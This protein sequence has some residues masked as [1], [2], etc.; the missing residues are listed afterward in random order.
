[1]KCPTCGDALRRKRYHDVIIDACEACKGLW[2]DERELGDFLQRYVEEHADV[3]NASM[4]RDSSP[5]RDAL[6]PEMQCPSCGV[7]MRETNYAYDSNVFVERCAQCGGIWTDKRGI[8]LLATYVRGNPK[9]DKLG[10]ALVKD[11]QKRQD[12]Q[13]LV[14]GIQ[15]LT[16]SPGLWVFVPKIVVPVGDN[17]GRR[18]F[19]FVTLGIILANVLLFAVMPHD[20]ETMLAFFTNY[21]LVPARF[22]SGEAVYGLVT[23]VFLHAGLWHLLGNA[24]FLWIF[25]DN[26]EDELGHGWFLGFYVGC[27]VMA[28]VAYL[29]LNPDSSIPM[30]GASGAIAGTMGAYMALHPGA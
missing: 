21:G 4:R 12:L 5:R 18:T 26:V 23:S 3:P 27:G 9:M 14:E 19:P 6:A 10:A 15:G 20:R 16:T 24:L 25:G 2:F 29:M 11:V 1:M 8:R 28:C 7:A 13:D 22:L 30:V 17:L